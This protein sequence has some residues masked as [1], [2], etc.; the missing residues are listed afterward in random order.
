MISLLH[1]PSPRS[2]Q[3]P[4][5]LPPTGFEIRGVRWQMGDLSNLD[6]T[7][8]SPIPAARISP[9]SLPPAGSTIRKVRLRPTKET[10][11]NPNRTFFLVGP[12]AE[13]AEGVE[14]ATLSPTGLEI[15]GVRQKI[16]E[17]SPIL[18]S[19]VHL[20]SPRSEHHPA[21]YPIKGVRVGSAK[22]SISS[23]IGRPTSP[24]RE[25]S[26]TRWPS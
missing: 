11:V 7:P 1:L 26:C 15:R 20:P 5:G 2:E 8:S 14:S 22:A 25:A 16:G 24:D 6:L 13:G 23:R 21:G 3:R 12:G 10:I 9:S 18:I 19:L 17:H 4:A